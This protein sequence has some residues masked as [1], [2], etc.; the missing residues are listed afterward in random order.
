MKKTIFAVAASCLL[1]GTVQATPSSVFAGL[2]V[3]T[4]GV[5]VNAGYK[6]NNLFKVR[7][8]GNYFKLNKTINDDDL[9]YKGKLR[10]FTIGALGDWHCLGNGFRVTGGLMYNGNQLNLNVTPS[11]SHSYNGVTYTPQQIGT[12]KGTLKFRR[13][14]PYLGIGFDSGHESNSGFS[15]NADLGVLFQGNVRGKINSISG[16]AANDATT[17][18][19]VKNDV[20]KAANKKKIIKYL[21]VISIGISYKF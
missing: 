9:T 5:G 1:I 7:A 17:I 12:V 3:S 19:N 2:G 21:P 18:E 16:L 15:F 14:A 10:M 20:V 6:V 11:S 13:V 4:L 8:V